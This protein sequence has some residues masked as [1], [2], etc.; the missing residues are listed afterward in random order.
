MNYLYITIFS[1]VP[2]K[3]IFG[4]SQVAATL[5][6]VSF[7][8]LIGSVSLWVEYYMKIRLLNIY[9]VFITFGFLFISFRWYFLNQGR[10]RK[11]LKKYEAS[12]KWVLKLIGIIFFILAF[13]SQIV[14][15]IILT[16]L[17]NN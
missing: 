1:F 14:T 11:N 7:F 13:S 4:R 12:N 15:G 17:R 2:R 8:F 9:S 5:L 16:I 3:A 10:L 6:S